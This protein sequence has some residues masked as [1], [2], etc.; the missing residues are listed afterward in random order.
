MQPKKLKN[1]FLPYH[2]FKILVYYKKTHMKYLFLVIMRKDTI[3]T[4]ITLVSNL[5]SYWSYFSI[6]SP[7]PHAFS[8]QRVLRFGDKRQ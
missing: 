3:V 6:D 5:L 4:L 2:F 8:R 7:L 1:N